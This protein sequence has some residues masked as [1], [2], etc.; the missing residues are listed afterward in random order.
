MR[1]RVFESIRTEIERDAR[2]VQPLRPPWKRALLVGVSCLVLCVLILV[3]AGLRTDYRNLQSV[4]WSVTLL[5]LAAAYSLA[6]PALRLV[7]PGRLPA[8]GLLAWLAAAGTAVQLV[9][10]A[11]IFRHSPS[12]PPLGK[13]LTTWVACLSVTV[14]LGILPA[15]AAFVLGS[16]GL[17]VRARLFGLVCGLSA[18]LGAEAAWRLHC[19][20]SDPLHTTAHTSAIVFLGIMALIAGAVWERR[21]VRRLWPRTVS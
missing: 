6:A 17:P 15:A 3:T 8:A 7:I 10:S 20:I 13:E 14:C 16:R 2:P 18:G 5:Q 12:F 19:P 1:D 9:A 11:L 4:L 21:H